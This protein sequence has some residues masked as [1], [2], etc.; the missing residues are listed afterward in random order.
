M[1]L[2]RLYQRCPRK[3]NRLATLEFILLVSAAVLISAILDELL[4]RISM[5]LIQVALGVVIALLSWNP[6]TLDISPDIFLLLFIAPLLYYEA[7]KSDRTSLWR[8][9]TSVLSLA[10][11]LVVAIMLIVGFSLHLLI[12]SVPL[13]AAFALGAALGPTDA[14]AVSSMKNEVKLTRRENAL[15]NGECL[16]NDASGVVAFQFAIA[17]SV[18]GFYSVQSAVVDFAVEFFGGIALGIIVALALQYLTSKVRDLGLESLTF[19]SLLDI[20]TPFLVYMAS[21]A[22]HV[23]GI[24]AVVACGLLISSFDDRRIGPS[25]SRLNI[26]QDNVWKVISFLLNGIVFVILGLELPLAFTTTWQQPY[27]NN[28]I[29]VGLVLAITVVLVL[30]RFLWL[31]AMERLHKNPVTGKRARLTF[32]RVLSC[33]ALTIGGPKGAVTLSII[34]SIPYTIGSGEA[35]PDRDLIIFVAS[36]VIL[37]TLVL[38]NFVLPLVSPS[39]Q[40]SEVTKEFEERT[41]LRIEILRNVIQRLSAEQ[42]DSNANATRAAI[43]MYNDRIQR[44]IAE[45]DEISDKQVEDMQRRLKVEIIRHQERYLTHLLDKDLVEPATAYRLARRLAL[46]EQILTHHRSKR[47]ILRAALRRITITLRTAITLLLQ[48]LPGV[49]ESQKESAVRELRILAEKETVRYLDHKIATGDS[50]YPPEMLGEAVAEH[51]TTLNT[52]IRTRPSIIFMAQ[53]LDD[54]DDIMRKAYRFE[55]EEIQDLYDEGEISRGLMK[56]LRENVYLMQLDLENRV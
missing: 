51:T 19:F 41:G 35:F 29:L 24:L 3:E 31:L 6:I 21:E 7:K 46:Q 20:V 25:V 50:K 2:Q 10:I 12:P 23:S 8:Q 56:L 52:L 55:L 16:L 53:T 1:F 49:D 32:K 44:I 54:T 28:G 47:W 40:K 38:A 37:C 14:V 26:H 18:T 11:G 48:A 45:T 34:L 4:P 27:I 15:L 5:P 22:I 42:R 9:R 36:G 30:V 17:A 33:V 43:A 39:P 13:A